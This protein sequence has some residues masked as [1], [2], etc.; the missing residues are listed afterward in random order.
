MKSSAKKTSVQKPAPRKVT[1]NDVGKLAGVSPATVSM[2]LSGREGVSFSDETVA[3]VRAAAASLRYE[4]AAD[5]RMARLV[6]ETIAPGNPM[7][8]IVCPN[9]L[10]PYYNT[11]VQAIQQSAARENCDSCVYITY[12]SLEGELAA[13]RLAKNAGFAGIVF[14][15]IAHPEEIIPRIGPRMPVVVISDRHA[16]L[17]VDTV[18]LNNYDAGSQV[19]VHMHELGHRRIA[20]ISTSLDRANSARTQR[21]KGLRETFLAL[22]PGGEVVVKSRDVSAEMERDDMEIE[23]SVGHE[24]ARKCF[25][26]KKITALV[27]INDMVAC[28]AIDAI[29]EAGFRVPEDYSVCGFDNILPSRFAGVSLTT[30]EHYMRDKG[31]NAFDILYAKMRGGASDRNIT[32]VEFKYRLIARASTAP[33]RR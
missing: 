17:D 7:I 14:T 15:M 9:V 13:L 30:V 1:L 6:R 2:I 19:A 18:E 33:P 23:Y 16:A 8:L 22:D 26:D 28:G 21:L 27:A 24:L 31:R 11:L 32:R 25:A 10:N 3:A 20:Y 29:R 5:R 12:R 4:T